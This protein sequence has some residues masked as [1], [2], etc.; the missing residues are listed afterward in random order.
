MI[1]CFLWALGHGADIGSFVQMLRPAADYAADKGV[2]L[3]LKNEAH[4]LSAPFKGC[5][6]S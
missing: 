6:A 3:V 4:E 5:S 1:D 2:T